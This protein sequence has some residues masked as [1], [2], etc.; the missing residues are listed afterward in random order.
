MMLQGSAF[1]FNSGSAFLV[2]LF[3][4]REFFRSDPDYRPA[5]PCQELQSSTFS[6]I[7]HPDGYLQRFNPR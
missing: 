6:L 3:K 2:C 7:F 4:L 5:L 1:V